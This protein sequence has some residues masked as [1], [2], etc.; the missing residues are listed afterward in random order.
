M[1]PFAN[2]CTVGAADHQELERLQAE[3]VEVK[4]EH[5]RKYAS[6]FEEATVRSSSPTVR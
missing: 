3:M 5:E 4:A 6:A 1:P 2:P